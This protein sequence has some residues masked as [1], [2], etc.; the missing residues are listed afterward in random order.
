VGEHG[1]WRKFT[2]FELGTRVPLIISA[3]WLA[4]A[5]AV[6][7]A[8]PRRSDAIVELVDLL[9][10][11]AALGGVSLP[12][13][14]SFDGVSLLPL[15]LLAMR[16]ETRIGD[17]SRVNDQ[18]N[19]HFSR[20]ITHLPWAKDAAF[21]QYPKKVRANGPAWENNGIIHRD[22]E[23][24]IASVVSELYSTCILLVSATVLL[25]SEWD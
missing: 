22:R 8:A 17:G 4:P 2:N 1:A 5:S 6:A 19:S 13:G 24:A 21:S 10:T 25:M 20:V 16:G 3:P 23:Y 14:E 9:P 11:I 18:Q 15:V 7:E 12:A